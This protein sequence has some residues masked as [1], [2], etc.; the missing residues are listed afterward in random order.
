MTAVESYSGSLNPGNV[1][2]SGGNV[3]ELRWMIIIGILLAVFLSYEAF[4]QEQL[5]VETNTANTFAGS[6]LVDGNMVTFQS[7]LVSANEVNFSIDINGDA[8]KATLFLGQCDRSNSSQQLC[9]EAITVDQVT[10]Q[11]LSV[12][13]QDLIFDTMNAVSGYYLK[14]P[15]ELYSPALVLVSAMGYWSLR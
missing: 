7:D 3:V 6:Y 10:G 8:R 13:Q 15:D 14:Q 9:S 5:S 11:A 12:E 2:K 4:A 1:E